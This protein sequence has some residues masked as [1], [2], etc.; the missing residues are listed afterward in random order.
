MAGRLIGG[1]SAGMG[2]TIPPVYINEIS[3]KR[4]RGKLG[5]FVQIQASLGIFLAFTFGLPSPTTGEKHR[6]LNDW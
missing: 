2:L 5:T 6:Y 4:I 1:V 3:P